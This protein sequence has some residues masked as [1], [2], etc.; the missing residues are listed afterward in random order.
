MAS[1][2]SPRDARRWPRRAALVA[3]AM[4]GMALL[5]AGSAW[6][7]WRSERGL[8]W[9]LG[10]VPGLELHGRHGRPDGGPF[11]AQLLVW[12]GSGLSVRIEGLSW[13]D[14]EWRWRPHPG[15]W[16]RL[17][18]AEPQAQGVHVTTG[19]P[20]SEPAAPPASLVLP[21]ELA[22]DNLR[23]QMVS[24]D[25]QT[26]L[27]DLAGDV[28]LGD[29]RGSVH[30]L[31]PL[32]GQR[33]QARLR[34]D[35]RIGTSGTMALQLHV[36]A[37]GI[38]PTPLPW[39]SEAQVSG[40]LERPVIQ[41]SLQ[42][43]SRGEAGR[44][45]LQATLAPFAPWPLSALQLHAQELDL[46]KLH[47]NLPS[48]RLDGRV[49][50]TS[51]GRGQPASA[52]VMLNNALPGLWSAGLVPV[53]A[54]HGTVRANR[55]SSPDQLAFSL[56]FARLHG[57]A[58][59]GLLSGSGRWAGEQLD[60]QLTLDSLL[61]AR[62]DD[63]FGTMT[64]GGTMQLQMRGLP[65]PGSTSAASS[66]SAASAA[67]AGPPAPSASAAQPTAAPPARPLSG[68]IEARLAGQL[69][70]SGAGPAGAPLRIELAS[71]L[72]QTADRMLT[73][74]LQNLRVVAGKA[75]AVLKGTIRKDPAG[76]WAVNGH[77][78][79]DRFD[80]SDWWSGPPGSAWR[81]GGHLLAGTLT[82]ELRW[83]T[84]GASPAPDWR[85][86]LRRPRGEL[87][88]ELEASRLAQVSLQ[89]SASL[90]ATER[91]TRL[92]AT[93]AAAGNRLQA[94]F[95]AG[96]TAAA[97]RWKLQ[98]DAPA[99][100]NLAP[101]AGLLPP[102]LSAWWPRRGA[103]AGEAHA[104]GTWPELS[105]EGR[106]QGH[107]IVVG[108]VRTQS[109]TSRAAGARDAAVDQ[110][111]VRWQAAPAQPTAPLQL[112]FE[113]R[114][115]RRT[116]QRIES[117]SARVGGSIAAH[118]FELSAAS[119]LRPPA[120]TDPLLATGGAPP[121]GTSLALAGEGRWSAARDGSGRWEGQLRTLQVGDRSR[122]GRPWIDA[123]G[124][125]AAIALSPEG[126]PVMA[127]L[128]PGSVRVREAQL[129]WTEARWE[130]PRRVGADA[131]F[132]LDARLQPVDVV[133]WLQRLQPDIAWQG[134]LRLGAAMRIR[135]AEQLNADVAIE[136]S[137]GDLGLNVQGKPRL[138]GLQIARL[139][140]SAHDG[141]WRIT[142]RVM[143]DQLGTFTG[144]QTVRTRRPQAVWPEPD[145][146]VSGS[147]EM[148]SA[149][150]DALGVWLPA[151]WRAKGRL[152]GRVVLSG[153]FDAPA[154]RGQLQGRELGASN[155]LLGVDVRDGRLSVAFDGQR[156]RLEQLELRAG[157]GTLS[158]SGSA[159]WSGAPVAR[160]QLAA[161]RF[162]VLGRLDRRIVIS[163]QVDASFGERL[164]ARGR[165]TVDSAFIDVSYADAP[166]LDEDVVV[167]NRPLGT[168]AGAAPAR[169]LPAGSAPPRAGSLLAG[170]DVEL[171]ID[172][173]DDLKL[174]GRGLETEL[175]G[176]LRVVARDGA[177]AMY[178][179]V[180][181]EGGTYAAYGQNLR[182]ERGV[183]LFTG[184]FANPRLDI[185]AL[186]PD[187]DVRVGV[188]IQGL[189]TAPRVRLYSEPP[190]SDMDRLSWLVM[191]RAPEGLGRADTALL[192]RAALALLAGSDGG[193]TPGLVSRLGLD[194]LTL[195]RGD[196]GE[197][198][199][200]VIALG[201]QLSERL[202][203]GY[204]RGLNAA[205]GSW[206]L[207]YRVARRLTLRLR[208]GED[209][210]L[211]AIYTWRWE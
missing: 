74:D 182:I 202:F 210:A 42:A 51:T 39:R 195:R 131:R 3:V 160:L 17:Q 173:G 27:T 125:Q 186:R 32:A 179:T 108:P 154:V 178:G 59:A 100:A 200:T 29:E 197:L 198:S 62:L 148:R 68:S 192:Q 28:H 83:P 118:R 109:G 162:E 153:R 104:V 144:E 164:R 155:L 121:R 8:D 64:L 101:I 112:T 172:L 77:G 188:T 199:D 105:T 1:N 37:E 60:V 141:T 13:R 23:V 156:A 41:G 168:A 185:L 146:P 5:L 25:G 20:T 102:S 50:V 55:P 35:G 22:L 201:K 194:E 169:A 138:F 113:A 86:A 151:G 136:R 26:V 130:A 46:G 193:R 123:G 89:G 176:Q 9:L 85:A 170:A 139:A 165:I 70:R 128:A 98:A 48:T 181:T 79:F 133:P 44:V 191:G 75:E 107:N 183:V 15:A 171:A 117:L 34:L 18:I 24:V 2:P 143:G 163:G 127:V 45:T 111:N 122:R 150:L 80:P 10:Q 175:R 96:P 66:A 12:R 174:S 161:N 94:A 115:L 76:I 69:G 149:D 53:E 97:D 205:A 152:E 135:M 129:E 203:I 78:R 52:E 7:I 95:N 142:Q 90:V 99:L 43:G 137:A 30:R 159:D 84:A 73:A 207:I 211:D 72:A 180:H 57:S 145:A 110:I 93:V 87:Q 33:E 132:A 166:A 206:Q 126:T 71:S 140:L 177:L 157:E 49:V 187:I 120:W 116:G 91:D 54:V 47:A 81:R 82:A 6:W 124:L 14:L 21:L 119:P 196:S 19:P 204:E 4:L 92:Q 61:P 31:G 134:D 58:P 40:P 147:V 36:E 184:D 56:E 38:D 67:S 167:I 114:G 190:M 16:L 208:T 11:S 88:L 106:L 103:I 209:S 63:R 65:V 189:V 158:G